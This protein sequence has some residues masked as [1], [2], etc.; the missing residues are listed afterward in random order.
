M[1]QKH[2]ADR[3]KSKF[4]GNT[5]GIT[6]L[7]ASIKR[8]RTALSD[9]EAGFADRLTQKERTTL[10]ETREI[11]AKLAWEA[12]KAKVE[13]KRHATEKQVLQERLRKESD[14]AVADAFRLDQVE[15]VIAFLGWDHKLKL[16]ISTNW[17]SSIRKEMT[18]DPWAHK[19][20]KPDVIGETRSQANDQ[21]RELSSSVA[22]EALVH[23]R[24]VAEIMNEALSDF[25][26]KRPAILKR[27]DGFIQ[28]IKVAGVAQ[29]ME[30]T[31]RNG[32]T[33]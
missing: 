29:A 9:I 16:W 28:E 13:V 14:K 20:R 18:T 5:K 2:L 25:H 6:T 31:N 11:L 33:G 8:T 26:S 24:A 7:A 10:N 4:G 1:T 23:G 19:Y 32:Q 3:Y 30:K 27:L 12:D 21:L 15:D 22:A 17:A